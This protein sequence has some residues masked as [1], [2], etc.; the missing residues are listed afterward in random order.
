MKFS[1]GRIPVVVYPMFWFLI[2]GISFLYSYERPH[3]IPLTLIW[4]FVIL[5]SVVV[6]ELGHALTALMFGQKTRIELYGMGGMTHRQGRKLKLWQEFFIVMNGPIAGFLLY[7]LAGNI[8]LAAYYP[9]ESLI[10]EA[11]TAFVYINLFWTLIN[12]IPVLPLDGGHLMRIIFE[13]A[14]GLRGVKIAYFFSMLL[15][16]IIGLLFFN[17]GA[18][19]AGIL[20]MLLA[21][22]SYRIWKSTLSLTT[23]DQD[24]ALQLKLSLA[25]R[26]M[27]LGNVN[28]ALPHFEELRST[29]KEGVIYTSASEHIAE[30]LSHQNKFKEAFE[31]LYPIRNKIRPEMLHLLH[32]IAYRS[33]K[34]QEAIIL[35][36]Q[37]YQYTPTY[38]TAVINALCHAI[39][40]DAVPA[41]GW[42]RCAIDEGLPNPQEI[43]S[44][45]EFDHI[46][47]NPSFKAL[48]G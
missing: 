15:S 37:S 42:L 13:G 36:N 22:E 27:R 7:F 16:G 43:L 32:Q 8:R 6:H 33:G 25:E 2:F 11:L 47:D 26:E 38:D 48:L 24:V 1:I 3:P 23:Q 17:L 18:I 31:I 4:A 34:W 45:R 19:I 46:R 29:A 28:D 30:I 14:F 35:G 9:P 10:S 41:I 39:V 12:L 20:F 44:K 5:I 21:F 40:G